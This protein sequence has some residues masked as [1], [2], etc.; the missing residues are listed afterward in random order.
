MS[1]MVN[2]FTMP[3][4]DMISRG[5]FFASMFVALAG[6]CLV[7]YYILGWGTNALAQVSSAL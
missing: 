4:S 1:S 7:S 6:V 3:V 5:D 2:V